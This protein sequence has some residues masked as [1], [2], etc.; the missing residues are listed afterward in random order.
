M[1]RGSEGFEKVFDSELRK[2]S[3]P[4]VASSS[5]GAEG[6]CPSVPKDNEEPS[7]RENNETGKRHRKQKTNY[8]NKKN[9][10]FG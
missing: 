9:E 4:A 7:K 6:S 1:R 5:S 2:V 3:A 8:G 10:L